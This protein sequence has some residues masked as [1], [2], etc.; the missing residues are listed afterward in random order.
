MMLRSPGLKNSR[1]LS[2]LKAAFAC[3]KLSTTS[4]AYGGL[5]RCKFIA[6]V[7]SAC[8]FI[9]NVFVGAAVSFLEP[10]RLT[11]R[12]PPRPDVLIGNPLT[13]VLHGGVTA[14]MID[15]VGGFAC[16]TTL[17]VHHPILIPTNCNSP[18]LSVYINVFSR[19]ITT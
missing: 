15:H 9:R 13:R 5:D 10:G 7:E 12:L 2:G 3:V 17:K 16:W 6:M 14:T 18:A 8:P 1:I 4:Q 19:R 11:M